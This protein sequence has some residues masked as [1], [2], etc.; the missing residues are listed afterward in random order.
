MGSRIPCHQLLVRTGYSSAANPPLRI[1]FF[2]EFSTS[3]KGEC[4]KISAVLNSKIDKR[5]SS[6]SADSHGSELIAEDESGVPATQIS[7]E[8]KSMCG[9]NAGEFVASVVGLSLRSL[10]GAVCSRS[11]AIAV[12]GAISWMWSDDRFRSCSSG[13]LMSTTQPSSC[14]RCWASKCRGL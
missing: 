4:W 13:C 10:D 7:C 1:D 8:V 12:T 2:N 11:K 9:S 5:S 14:R 6:V 3:P